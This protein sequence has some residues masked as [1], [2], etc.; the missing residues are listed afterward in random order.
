M[1][2]LPPGSFG[3]DLRSTAT[4]AAWDERVDRWLSRLPRPM[5][6]RI[7]WLRVPSRRGLRLLAGTALVLGGTLSFLPV[8]GLWMLPLGLALLAQDVPTLKVFME[9]RA[10]WTERQLRRLR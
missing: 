6:S 4:A 10:R 8:L 7:D 3:D 2:S 1:T 9:R 5:R